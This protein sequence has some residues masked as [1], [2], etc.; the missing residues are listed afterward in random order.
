MSVAADTRLDW[1]KFWVVFNGQMV[2][3]KLKLSENQSVIES[4]F[5]N[6]KVNSTLFLA[7]LVKI[8]SA[9]KRLAFWLQHEISACPGL[10]CEFRPG[11]DA[12]MEQR[13][14][15]SI[16][17]S[18]IRVEF[19]LEF[20]IYQLQKTCSRGSRH[21]GSTITSIWSSRQRPLNR[22]ARSI[23]KARLP[24]MIDIS[25]NSSVLNQKS[26]RISP[27]LKGSS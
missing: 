12:K 8:L 19:F 20:Y 13:C 17:S 22:D 5:N 21:A 23:A 15:F 10:V 2:S 3:E 16:I 9:S 14:H 18:K 26:D 24:D 25:L 6:S 27:V 7:K 11:L 4:F 1:Y